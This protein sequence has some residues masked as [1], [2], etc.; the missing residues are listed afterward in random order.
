MARNTLRR[1]ETPG[2]HSGKLTSS[3]RLCVNV[4]I[5][6]S[7]ICSAVTLLRSYWRVLLMRLY[8]SGVSGYGAPSLYRRAATS[9]SRGRGRAG[10]ESPDDLLR[11]NR[12]KKNTMGIRRRN[13]NETALEKNSS[14]NL[15]VMYCCCGNYNTFTSALNSKINFNYFGPA[16]HK[17]DSRDINLGT[18]NP[19]K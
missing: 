18:E 5:S 15:T 6:L 9:R 17:M 4:Y 14:V 2:I 11:R 16:G 1:G 19:S 13:M 7:R 8:P 10:G 3:R 12:K